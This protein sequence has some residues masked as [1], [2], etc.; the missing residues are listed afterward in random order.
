MGDPGRL[1]QILINLVGNA[2]FEIYPRGEIALKVR[3]EVAEQAAS[4]LHFTVADTGVGIAAEKLSTI[5]ESFNQADT[6]TTREV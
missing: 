1:R 5:F 4:V 3:T 6:S 2:A